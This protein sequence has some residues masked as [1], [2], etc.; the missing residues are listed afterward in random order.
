MIADEDND[1]ANAI[2]RKAKPL[3]GN[4]EMFCF[5]GRQMRAYPSEYVLSVS[6]L[7]LVGF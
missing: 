5:G 4:F 1:E 2:S 6:P 7:A 3:I